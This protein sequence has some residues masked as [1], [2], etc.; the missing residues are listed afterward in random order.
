MS[1]IL[2]LGGSYQ[3][4]GLIKKAVENGHQVVV[5]DRDKNCLASRMENVNF[6]PI[7]LSDITIVE[8]LVNEENFDALIPPV[9]E[10]GNITAAH[11]ADKYDFLY[12]SI[13]TVEATTKKIIM[14]EKLKNSCLKEPKTS[15]YKN[16]KEVENE[17][18]T[19][20]MVKPSQSSASRG[21]TLVYKWN[22]FEEA[23]EYALK[24]CDRKEEIIIE[25]FIVG[26][27]YSIETVSSNN[28]H[29]I[30]GITRE[31]MSGPPYFVERTDVIKQSINTELYNNFQ[32]YIYKLLSRLDIK[33]GPCHIE[34]KITDER[35]IYLI[36]VASRSGMLRDRLIET[37]GASDY[38]ELIINSYLGEDIGPDDIKKPTHNALLGVMMTT[39][40]MNIFLR[41]KKDNVLFNEY[42]LGKGP[43]INPKRLTDAYGYFFVRSNTDILKYKLQ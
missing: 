24:F 11:I 21:A 27:Q 38:N 8:K 36:E 12:N 30:V 32:K 9:T 4:T 23:I 43:K 33:V 37:S 15:R 5:I 40:D 19:P 18:N 7:D 10:L 26:E 1:K 16:K 28:Q 14:R 17:F 22:Q 6:Y 39:K 3:Q 25:E 41:A 20:V 31:Y 29:F 13:E 42:F 35:E 34:V 2:V